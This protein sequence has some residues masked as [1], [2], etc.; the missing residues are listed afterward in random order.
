MG[1]IMGGTKVEIHKVLTDDELKIV[2]NLAKEI[3]EEYYPEIIG[4][5]QVEYM[6]KKFQA[7]KPMKKEIEEEGYCYFLIYVDFVPVGYCS[8]MNEIES[9]FLSKIY[10]LKK[11]RGTGLSRLLLTQ[12]LSRGGHSS[13]TRIWLRVN[14]TNEESIKVYKGI[15]LE[16]EREDVCD[17]GNGY[18]MDDYIMGGMYSW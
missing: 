14:K 9:V 12:A 5:E 17:I 4:M 15:G 1:A 7:F 8:I 13:P 16:I 11:Y 18:V 2:E 10:V 6:V 3:W